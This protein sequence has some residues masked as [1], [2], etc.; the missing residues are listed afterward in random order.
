MDILSKHLFKCIKEV[1]TLS[2]INKVVTTKRAGL[3]FHPDLSRKI[4]NTSWHSTTSKWFLKASEKLS[5][6]LG[7]PTDVL[8]EIRKS[9]IYEIQCQTCPAVYY[10][11]MRRSIEERF[12]EHISMVSTGAKEKSSVAKHL[13]M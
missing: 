4:S 1:T 6:V 7:S 5:Q 10:G 13:A 2:P 9:G 3:L 11:Q 12:K 8:D